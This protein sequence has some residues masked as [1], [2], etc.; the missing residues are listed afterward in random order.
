MEFSEE[1]R[2]ALYN[3]WMSQKAKMHLTQME[4]AKRL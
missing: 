4:M 3:A 1:D 2:Q